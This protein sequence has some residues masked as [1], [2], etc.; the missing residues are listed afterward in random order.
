MANKTASWDFYNSFFEYSNTVMNMDS[1]TFIFLIVNSTHVFD[2]TDTILSDIDN[3]LSGNGYSRQTLT[4]T[5][6]RSGAV[7]KFDFSDVTISASG[8]DLTMRRFVIFNDTVASPVKPLVGSGLLDNADAD[9]V[10]ADGNDLV[11]STPA[12]GQFTV[13]EAA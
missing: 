9:V 1:D 4:H 11:Y 6:T 12:G 3:E 5:Y 8:G 13:Q 10:L 2:A 7:G